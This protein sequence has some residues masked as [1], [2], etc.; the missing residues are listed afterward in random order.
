LSGS[1]D[2][3]RHYPETDVQ[4]V[5]RRRTVL[6]LGTLYAPGVGSSATGPRAEGSPHKG[7]RHTLNLTSLGAKTEASP[8]EVFSAQFDYAIVFPCVPAKKKKRRRGRA[9]VEADKCGN[10]AASAVQSPDAKYVIHTLIQAGL[11][12]YPYLSLQRNELI[13]LFRAPVCRNP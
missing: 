10:D 6:G 3:S 1:G 12:V 2:N 13:V 4:D 5:A 7:D 9:V 8:S 11:E